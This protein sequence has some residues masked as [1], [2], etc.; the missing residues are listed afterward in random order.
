MK[1]TSNL[2]EKEDELNRTSL[3]LNNKDKIHIQVEKHNVVPPTP[4]PAKLL[5][6]QD[7]TVRDIVSDDMTAGVAA[8]R[9]SRPR[10]SWAKVEQDGQ[11]LTRE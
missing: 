4:K 10:R 1:T 8:R 6:T 11:V 7:D 2:S 9:K 5:I 3:T